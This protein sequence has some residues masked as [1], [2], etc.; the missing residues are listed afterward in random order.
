[1]QVSLR[2]LLSYL[3][4]VF[5]EVRHVRQFVAEYSIT[6]PGESELGLRFTGDNSK[7]IMEKIIQ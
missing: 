2:E 6:S 3:I 5:S 4:S 7:K 1:M